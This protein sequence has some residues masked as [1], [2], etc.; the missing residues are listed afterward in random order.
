M[1][2]AHQFDAQK[3][4]R[5]NDLPKTEQPINKPKKGVEYKNILEQWTPFETKPPKKNLPK[6]KVVKER[7]EDPVEYTSVVD[8][9][10]AFSGLNLDEK[11]K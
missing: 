6:K 1:K 11:D 3:Y 10:S 8:K 4:F 5:T 7:K 2:E 9:W